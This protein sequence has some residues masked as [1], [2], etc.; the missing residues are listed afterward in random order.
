MQYVAIA[1]DDSSIPRKEISRLVLETTK[2]TIARDTART[3]SLTYNDES[4]FV[5]LYEESDTGLV[6]I[7]VYSGGA[8]TA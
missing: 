6:C 8:H 1:F 4:Q 2:E 7:A 3:A 5:A